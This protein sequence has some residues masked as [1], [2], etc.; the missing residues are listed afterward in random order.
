MKKVIY[1]Y[2]LK[3]EDSFQLEMPVEAV[4][5][6]IDMQDGKPYLWAVVYPDLRMVTYTFYCLGTGFELPDNLTEEP[7]TY[8]GTLFEGPFVWHFWMNSPGF[9]D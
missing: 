2:P 7:H 5:L 4:P 3:I 1:K 9:M 6:R 8:I